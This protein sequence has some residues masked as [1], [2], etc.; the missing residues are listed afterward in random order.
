MTSRIRSSLSAIKRVPGRAL[1]EINKQ[2]GFRLLTKAGTK[3]VL[4]LTKLV[5]L[6]GGLIGGSFDA[7]TTYTVGH[8]AAS[9]FA[10]T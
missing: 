8:C 6:V 3:G 5:P 4:N 1:I 2:V 9:T 7:A 10:C